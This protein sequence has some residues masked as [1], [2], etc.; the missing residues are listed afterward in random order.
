MDFIELTYEYIQWSMHL[1]SSRFRVP[2]T[3]FSKIC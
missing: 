2:M 1:K 3:L